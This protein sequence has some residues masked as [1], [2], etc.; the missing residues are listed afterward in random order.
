MDVGWYEKR[1]LTCKT[2]LVMVVVMW[3]GGVGG[4][5]PTYR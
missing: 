1:V 3:Q 5:G 2:G 4:V